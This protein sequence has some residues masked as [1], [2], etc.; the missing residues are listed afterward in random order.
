[1]ACDPLKIQAEMG[2]YRGRLAVTKVI[3]LALL[4]GVLAFG[5][6]T[7]VL[8]RSRTSRDPDFGAPLVLAAAAL[9]VVNITAARL[10]PRF[11]F[12]AGRA[13]SGPDEALRVYQVF[14]IVRSS[15]L[16][17]AALLACVATLVTGGLGPVYVLGVCAAALALH[18]PTED[19][20]VGL[21]GRTAP[22]PEWPRQQGLSK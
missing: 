5:T 2:P 17:G 21:M 22:A 3:H 1:M 20:F 19:E 16:E 15:L 14:V 9:A 7:L 6:V 4:A 11:F 8:S 12:R 18:R 10:L 13:L